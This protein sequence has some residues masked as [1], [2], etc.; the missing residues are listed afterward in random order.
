MGLLGRT[1]FVAALGC[2]PLACGARPDP[3]GRAEADGA[4]GS[5]GL[6]SGSEET[7]GDGVVMVESPALPAPQAKPDAGAPPAGSGDEEVAQEGP[8]PVGS[9]QT[10]VACTDQGVDCDSI[11]VAVSDVDADVCIQLTLDNCGG[12]SRPGLPIDLPVSWRLGSASLDDLGDGC[13][14]D[15]YDPN[16][17]V[18][19]DASGSISWNEDGVQPS[20]LVIEV[21]L[22]P[23]RSA[24]DPAPITIS[25]GTIQGIVPECDG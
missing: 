12:Y 25:N 15:A 7:L 22:T 2:V 9:S 17:I 8:E 5:G 20:E 10:L 11:N 3:P 24:P 16:N 1:I 6:V 18:I 19:I 13:V 21:T 4:G 14:P 23:S